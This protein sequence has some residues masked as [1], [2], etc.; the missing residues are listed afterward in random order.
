[1]SLGGG[2][3]QS[4]NDAVNAAD[5]AGI[6]VVVAAG[7]SGNT[8]DACSGSP[9]GATGAFTVGATT[10]T[11]AIATYSSNGAC[12][13]ILAPG[14]SVY[15]AWSTSNTA[16]STISGTSMATPHV[17]GLAALYWADGNYTLTDLKDKLVFTA[18]PGIITGVLGASN[19][20]LAR[21]EQV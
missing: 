16:Y 2:F 13:D 8:F 4:V 14:S 1:M 17:A 19:N 12:V 18:T 21:Y 5:A 7:N 3:S 15:S 20:L 10:I 6:L 9:A 11:D